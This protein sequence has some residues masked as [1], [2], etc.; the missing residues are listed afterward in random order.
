VPTQRVPAVR[1]VTDTGAQHSGSQCQ[2]RSESTRV[3]ET[4]LQ[5]IDAGRA[6]A[7][8]AD[9]WQD[10]YNG[11][12]GLNGFHGSGI[13]TIE[14][15]QVVRVTLEDG[16]VTAPMGTYKIVVGTYNGCRW[17]RSAGLSHCNNPS[18]HLFRLNRVSANRYSGFH[19]RRLSTTNANAMVNTPAARSGKSPATV[20]W[21][22]NEPSPGATSV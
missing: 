7:A 16:A 18:R 11:F 6:P 9:T 4:R 12:Y 15:D 21:V 20:A 22:I 19:T 3:R 14:Q 8:S 1:Q 17:A 5:S 13:G 10:D 2:F